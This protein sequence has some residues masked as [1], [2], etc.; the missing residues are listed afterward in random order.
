MKTNSARR[1]LRGSIAIE[2][3]VAIGIV[4]VAFAILVKISTVHIVADQ[5]QRAASAAARAVAI[6]ASANA[7]EVALSEIGGVA[8]SGCS[9]SWTIHV[10]TE[11]P[12]TQ[13]AA[14][15]TV[16]NPPI[17]ATGGKMV[18]VRIQWMLDDPIPNKPDTA[19][20]SVGIQRREW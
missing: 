16:G 11:V 2:G 9:G 1:R 18:V 17:G 19:T 14:A 12:I 13:L 7:C 8:G 4:T 3:V 10:D 15:G 20:A 5:L 6:D